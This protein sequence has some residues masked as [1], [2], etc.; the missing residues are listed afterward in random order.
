MGEDKFHGGK[1]HDGVGELDGILVFLHYL[2]DLLQGLSTCDH[3]QNVD[4]NFAYELL[5]HHNLEAKLFAEGV[6]PQ[7]M[8]PI[9]SL[10]GNHFMHLNH[11]PQREQSDHP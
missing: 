11:L 4:T 10:A 2:M 1:D 8:V 9:E 6:L 3:V 7:L 5:R